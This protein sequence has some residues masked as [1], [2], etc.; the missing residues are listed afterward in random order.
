MAKKRKVT[1]TEKDRM[2]R[3]D[4]ETTLAPGAEFTKRVNLD[5]PPWLLKAIDEEATRRG[6][7]RQAL[8][9]HWLTDR[10]DE[11]KKRAG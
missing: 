11:L 10:V 1:E 6:I 5:L 4:E 2:M 9:K 3:E 7:A 8:I